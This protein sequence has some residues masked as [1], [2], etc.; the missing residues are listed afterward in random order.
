MSRSRTGWPWRPLPFHAVLLAAYPVLFLFA[1]NLAEVTTR[2]V[3]PPLGRAVIA[4]ATVAMVA[5]VALRDLRRGALIGAALIVAWSV[6]GHGDALL[7]PMGVSRDV[8]LAGW[9]VFVAVALLAAVLLPGR[10]IARTTVALN[11]AAT[12]LVAMTLVQIL[13]YQLSHPAIA[14]AGSQTI[15]TPPPGDRAIYYLIFDRYG[16]ERST[17][18]FTG[19]DNDLPQWLES[20][21]FTV[22]ADS[23]ANYGRTLLSLGATLNLGSL[24]AVA[25]QM[26]PT[27]NNLAPVSEMLQ[28]NQVGR[29][30]KARGYRYIHLGSWYGPTR[31]VRIADENPQLE[32]STDFEAILEKTTF[33]PTLDD[34]RGVEDPPKDEANHRNQALFQFRMLPQVA[35]ERS[36]KFVFAHILLP[37]D[38]YVF[39]AVGNYPSKAE[40]KTR[41]TADK[42]EQQLTF[43]NT[44][45]RQIVDGLLSGPEETRPIVIIQADEGPYPA[46][47]AA[48]WNHFDWATATSDELEIKYGILNAMYLPGPAP[49][50]A[51]EPY[52]SISSWNTFRLVFDRYFGTNYQLLPD[53]SYTSKTY[54]LPYDLTDVTDRLPSLHG[55]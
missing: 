37:H 6:F 5:A 16:S 14:A 45:I 18:T 3:V 17:Q 42:F 27:S 31:T 12:V 25:A 55:Q 24:D 49:A 8:Q 48:D 19:I 10:W 35:E 1:D 28:D 38:P 33:G 20:R 30:L 7:A 15:G 23:H 22:A 11:V 41:T 52:P 26:G 46:R 9:L 40:R 39:D 51:P 43:T 54:L 36:P 44:H 13:P 50:D 2:D 4:G 29:F 34:L 32:T 53:R 21:G 47:Y